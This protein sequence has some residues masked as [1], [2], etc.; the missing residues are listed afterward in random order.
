MA[1]AVSQR[2]VQWVTERTN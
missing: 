1:V 2:C